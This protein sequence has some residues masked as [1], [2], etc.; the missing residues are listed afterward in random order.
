MS[1]AES[2]RHKC[3]VPST[4]RRLCPDWTCLGAYGRLSGSVSAIAR[5]DQ[6]Y[7]TEKTHFGTLVEI[8]LQREFGFADGVAMDFAIQGVDAPFAVLNGCQ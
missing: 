6:L 5:W 7:K 8:N 3:A 2:S 1:R 4:G